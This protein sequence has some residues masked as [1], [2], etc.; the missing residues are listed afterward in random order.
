[1]CESNFDRWMLNVKRSIT[2][3]KEMEDNQLVVKE[4]CKQY[5]KP[6]LLQH[7]SSKAAQR[8]IRDIEKVAG[9]FRHFDADHSG[10][11]EPHEFV[12][13][14]SKLMQQPACELDTSEVWKTWDA[15][16]IDGSG[17]ISY[18]EF[19]TWYCSAFDVEKVTDFRDF[20][21]DAIV[22]EDQK[23]MREVATKL[24]ID[25]VEI[26]KIWKEFHLIDADSSGLID[27]DEFKA[28]IQQQISPAPE[29][30]EVPAK[31][32]DKFWMDVDCDNSG[33]ISFEEFAAWYLKFLRGEISPMEKYYQMVGTGFR[34]ALAW[35]MRDPSQA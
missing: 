34:R 13:L 4:K 7:G 20:F 31:V 11:I 25:Y 17:V 26:E 19:H 21:S 12:P 6:P 30:P 1:M 18:E 10:V 15:V 16:D 32:V 9:I 14:L 24:G 22:S 33:S 3:Q 8:V 29:S 27:Y 23:H 35:S 2:Q 28:L 5:E